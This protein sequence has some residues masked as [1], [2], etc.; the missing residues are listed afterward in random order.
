[1]PRP[2]DCPM[3]SPSLLNGDFHKNAVRLKD[4]SWSVIY[5]SFKEF[6]F[7][8]GNEKNTTTI[9]KEMKP[10]DFW[11]IFGVVTFEVLFLIAYISAVLFILYKI[12]KNMKVTRTFL[13]STFL[14]IF[15]AIES[16][17]FSMMFVPL[18]NPL[19]L[20]ILLFL[21]LNGYLVGIVFFEK[22]LQSS[23]SD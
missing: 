18:D 17:I 23:T 22:V 13:I 3:G 5:S 9:A 2:T 11:V 1:M 4:F 7:S 14:L 8:D 10:L 20:F 6:L 12:T 15:A 19:L 21:W 16:W